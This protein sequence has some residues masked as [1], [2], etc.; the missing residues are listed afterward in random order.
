MASKMLIELLEIVIQK[1]D[2][3]KNYFGNFFKKLAYC[4]IFSSGV[5]LLMWFLFGSYIRN[6][7]RGKQL[8]SLAKST[9]QAKFN[10]GNL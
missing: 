2:V 4:L 7:N 1:V 10:R 9:P 5:I 6:A 8:G 3:Q